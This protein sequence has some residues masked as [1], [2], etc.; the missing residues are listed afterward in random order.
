MSVL[1]GLEEWSEVIIPLAAIALGFVGLVCG[2]G[3]SNGAN[4]QDQWREQE[5]RLEGEEDTR[6]QGPI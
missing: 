6:D 1:H 2:V 4:P 3:R 5:R